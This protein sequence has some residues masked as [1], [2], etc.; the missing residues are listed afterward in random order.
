MKPSTVFFCA[1]ISLYITIFR[2]LYISLNQTTPQIFKCVSTQPP[3]K[4]KSQDTFHCCLRTCIIWMEV[5]C[6]LMLPGEESKVPVT[7][8]RLNL[9][10]EVMSESMFYHPYSVLHY[11]HK[12]AVL[13]VNGCK[14]GGERGWTYK[15]SKASQRSGTI[16]SDSQQRQKFDRPALKWSKKQQFWL[17]YITGCSPT[18]TLMW[19]YNIEHFG[20]WI[21]C[22][23][24]QITTNRTNRTDVYV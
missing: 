8:L 19:S 5:T 18:T 1:T 2:C 14:H 7:V 13:R 10:M 12:R 3:Q 24:F 16:K 11:G 4:N 23:W 9:S 22:Y 20:Q 21:V 15:H 6:M 17:C